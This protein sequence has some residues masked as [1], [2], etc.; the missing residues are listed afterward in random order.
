MTIAE[1]TVL[2]V[3]DE[4]ELLEIFS[5]WI[6][7]YG[8][9]VLKASNGAEALKILS[10]RSVN[11]IVSDIRMPIMDGV[12]L[13]RSLH[14]LHLEIPTVIFVSGFGDVDPRVLY[15][16]GV[17]AMLPKPLARARLLRTLES[18]L[19]G[20]EERWLDPLPDPA[21]ESISADFP[22]LEEA[23]AAHN[24][25]LGRGGC[26]VHCVKV[27]PDC[28]VDLHLSFT[29]EALAL[30]GQGIVRWYDTASQ[31]AGVEFAYLAP[32]SRGWVLDR[33]NSPAIQCFIPSC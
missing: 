2:V 20:R 12:T 18:S 14:D 15:S 6:K 5:I 23:V 16:L 4:P 9:S 3:D 17:E 24:F 8:A 1:A 25:L 19:R 26:C 32:S 21:D 29:S 31:H 27:I 10:T 11:A 13:I 30:E 33:I 7:R 28:T 22:S